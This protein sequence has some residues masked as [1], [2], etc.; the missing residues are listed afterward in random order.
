[1]PL[2]FQA[3]GYGLIL[4]DGN[5]ININRLKKFNLARVDKLFKVSLAYV[6]EVVSKGI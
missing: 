1:M 3:V 6:G 2:H 5:V 4:L